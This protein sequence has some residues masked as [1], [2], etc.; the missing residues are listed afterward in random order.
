MANQIGWLAVRL[1]VREKM[2]GFVGKT[3][4]P[5]FGKL[6]IYQYFLHTPQ[7]VFVPFT[8][9]TGVQIPLGTPKKTTKLGTWKKIPQSLFCFFTKFLQFSSFFVAKLW[10]IYLIY[11]FNIIIFSIFLC[12][13]SVAL[14]KPKKR[15]SPNA[16]QLPLPVASFSF[17]H[18][19]IQM[20][21]TN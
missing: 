14:H 11:P 3:W 8:P 5:M 1:A 9:V 17:S 4:S 12:G 2:V 18:L 7:F 15:T 21:I 20:F 19:T 16:R 10:Q 13:K 6:L